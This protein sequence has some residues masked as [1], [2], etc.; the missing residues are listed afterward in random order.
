MRITKKLLSS[1]VKQI[2][3]SKGLEISGYRIPRSLILTEEYDTYGLSIILE[4]GGYRR[5][6]CGMTARECYYFLKGILS[7]DYVYNN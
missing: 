3:E 5:V 4:K 6:D 1:L 2:N 7:K